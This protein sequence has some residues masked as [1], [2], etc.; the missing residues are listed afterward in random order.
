[1]E[2]ELKKFSDWFDPWNINHIKAYRHLQTVGMWPEDFIPKDI[3][4]D[5]YW[6]LNIHRKMAELWVGSMIKQYLLN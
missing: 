2:N 4:M 5:I 6:Q 1:M 3:Y